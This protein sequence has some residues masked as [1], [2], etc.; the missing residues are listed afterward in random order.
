MITQASRI[1]RQCSEF[2]RL[3]RLGHKFTQFRSP[4]SDV[5]WM[6]PSRQI[7]WSHH[8][9]EIQAHENR[10]ETSR[11]AKGGLDRDLLRGDMRLCLTFRATRESV[12]P[13]LCRIGCPFRCCQRGRFAL[14]RR[15]CSSNRGSE[16]LFSGRLSLR[17]TARLTS[18]FD[19]KGVPIARRMFA[20][21]TEQ[22]RDRPWPKRTA[23]CANDS[24]GH[25]HHGSGA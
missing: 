15:R 20:D 4:D 22:G 8:C 17:S 9:C 14:R 1:R 11:Y 23:D 6:E 10:G 18:A 12:C 16:G 5:R 21:I 2:G 7:H 13:E 25:L 3:R 24:G 19:P